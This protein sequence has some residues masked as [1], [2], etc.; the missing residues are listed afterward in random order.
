MDN[1][2]IRL[3]Y[4]VIVVRRIRYLSRNADFK[5][6]YGNIIIAAIIVMFYTSVLM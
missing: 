3:F 6:I 5:M 2:P 4:I 1:L